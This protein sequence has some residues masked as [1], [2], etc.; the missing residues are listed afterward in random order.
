MSKFKRKLLLFL[1]ADLYSYC[2]ENGRYEYA[3]TVG[4]AEDC[5]MGV[6]D[7]L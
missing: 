2:H 1:L 5:V 3:S 6:L 7:N 4:H